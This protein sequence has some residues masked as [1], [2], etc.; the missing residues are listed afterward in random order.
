M[1][2]FL[3]GSCLGASGAG[4][5]DHASRPARNECGEEWSVVVV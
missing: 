3:G 4:P 2:R 5:G 1:G